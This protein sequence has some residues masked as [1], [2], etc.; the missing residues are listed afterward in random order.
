MTFESLP[1]K[2]RCRIIELALPS[3]IENE[4]FDAY[5]A[6]LDISQGVPVRRVSERKLK[7]IVT[8]TTQQQ[9]DG[10]TAEQSEGDMPINTKKQKGDQKKKKPKKKQQS[11]PKSEAVKTA[12]V[13]HTTQ[14]AE[15]CDVEYAKIRR[16]ERREEIMKDVE[17][18]H[19]SV[20]KELWTVIQRFI[21]VSK[22]FALDLRQG[23]RCLKK[24]IDG[25]I[26]DRIERQGIWKHT[27]PR[28]LYR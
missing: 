22:Q 28:I 27:Y 25:M 10:Y 13:E 24:D 20:I 12:L 18:I 6:T 9:S 26:T 2:L 15:S 16:A 23:I 5:M 8:E 17:D 3:V 4:V 11:Q 7:V 21:L 1:D 14:E 19:R